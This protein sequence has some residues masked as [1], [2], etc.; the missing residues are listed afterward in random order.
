MLARTRDVDST[1]RKLVYSTVL[2][3]HCLVS[4]PDNL[5][6]EAEDEQAMGVTHPQVL[7][8]VQRELIVRN[9]LGDREETVKAAASKLIANWVD[10]IRPPNVKPENGQGVAE[11][12]LLAFLDLFDLV[13]NSTA[14]DALTSIF[15]TRVDLLDSLQFDGK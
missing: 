12:D 2:E 5:K 10:I 15:V 6:A 13:A 7:S 3:Q 1:I 11:A 8:I 9:G 14:E 4:S